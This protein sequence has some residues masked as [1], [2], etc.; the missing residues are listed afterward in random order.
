MLLNKVKGVS[1]VF[2]ICI[3]FTFIIA[4]FPVPDQMRETV[5][6]RVQ[7]IIDPGHGLPDGGAV[8]VDGTAEQELNLAIANKVCDRLIKTKINCLLTRSDER[9]IYTEGDSIHEKKVSDIRARI[10]LAG[11]YKGVPLI[12]IHLNTFPDPSVHGIQVFYKEGDETSLA[13]AQDLQNEFN[14]KIQF[15]NAKVVKKISKNIY[16]FSH[17]E[18]PAIL[19]ECGFISN[20]NE[21]SK[22]KTEE[23]QTE[24][25]QIIA[26]VLARHS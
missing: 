1:I 25:A 21:L 15:D 3:V 5:G 16:L 23:Y 13:L 22:L 17:V 4:Q 10:D 12:S 18:N 7:F 26:D 24:I 8:G 6:E 19:V 2:L 20:S 11:K 9:S 14:K